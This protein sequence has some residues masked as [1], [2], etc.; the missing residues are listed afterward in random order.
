M[1]PGDPLQGVEGVLTSERRRA[2]E[3]VVEQV[4]E[5]EEVRTVIDRLAGRL[6]GR[7]GVGGA[8]DGAARC[9]G[10]SRMVAQGVLEEGSGEAEIEDLGARSWTGCQHDV[11]GLEVAVDQAFSMGL[12]E[13]GG[14]LADQ[15]DDSQEVQVAG[16]DRLR[17]TAPLDVLHDDRVP[18]VV[19]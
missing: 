6:L 18:G 17:Q 11:L 12:A 5:G 1:V 14:D 8:D 13:A 10:I 4:A 15:T 9:Q 7:H 16:G 2:R 19:L 3:G